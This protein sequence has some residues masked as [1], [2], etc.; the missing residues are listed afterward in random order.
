MCFW[1]F[2]C[3][4]TLQTLN[5]QAKNSFNPEFVGSVQFFRQGF[6][7]SGPFLELNSNDFLELRFDVFSSASPD[8]Y[9]SVELCD[10]NWEPVDIDPMDYTEGF[11]Y[12][13]FSA[14]SNS[15]NTTVDYVHYR[16]TIPN[17]D[18]SVTQGGNYV[19]RIFKNDELTDTLLVQRFV[20]YNDWVNVQLQSDKYQS[21]LSQYYQ[22][23]TADIDP[24]RLTA[25]DLSGN[26]ILSVFQN[27]NWNTIKTFSSYSVNHTG[28]IVFNSP[29]QIVFNGRNEFRIFDTKSLKHYS[30]RI[31][32]IE[33]QPPYYH[34]FLKPDQ[35]RGDKQYFTREDLN[36]IFYIDNSDTD[37]DDI[38]DADYVYVHFTL[39]TGYPFPA[40]IYI[41]GAFTN[42]EQ[43]NNYMEFDPQTGSYSKQLLLKQGLYN[44]RY[45]MKE[46]NIP[47]FTTDITEGDFYQTI[48]NYVAIVYYKPLGEL[49]HKPIGI[50]SFTTN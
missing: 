21:K 3:I 19:L 23:L 41:D 27:N 11:L 46:Y 36:G 17:S 31:N 44:Y 47:E 10:Y 49:Y 12:N 14:N 50:T 35:T 2:L 18:F 20:V 24:M 6:P 15:I 33:Y 5:A 25:N 40:D 45:I 39:E 1:A 48:N 13:S 29:G 9:Y 16:L 22:E 8:L 7:L 43:S 30:E 34:V 26:I 38:I 4:V 42:W 32:Y 37:D 28:L